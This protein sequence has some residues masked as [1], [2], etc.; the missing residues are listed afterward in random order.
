MMAGIVVMIG[1]E[2]TIE[3]LSEATNQPIWAQAQIAPDTK[4]GTTTG[5]NSSPTD[6]WEDRQAGS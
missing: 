3:R 4:A 5:R 6:Q 1:N 2:T